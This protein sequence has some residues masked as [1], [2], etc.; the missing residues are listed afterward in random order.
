MPTPIPGTAYDYNGSVLSSFFSGDVAGG[1]GPAFGVEYWNQTGRVSAYHN[2]YSNS[3]AQQEVVS[4]GNNW[5]D[6]FPNEYTQAVDAWNSGI[7]S[8]QALGYTVNL[9]GLIWDQGGQDAI[10]LDPSMGGLGTAE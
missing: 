1:F 2:K 8:L 9:R 10:F 6:V 5:S 3:S 4:P 7:T